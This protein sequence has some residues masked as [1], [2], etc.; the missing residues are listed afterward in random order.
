MV[1]Q[2]DWQEGEVDVELVRRL[3]GELYARL[4]VE[5]EPSPVFGN[6]AL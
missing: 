3:R 2:E 6:K 5:V 1:R 4:R